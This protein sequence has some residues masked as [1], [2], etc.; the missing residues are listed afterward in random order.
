MTTTIR[1]QPDIDTKLRTL[2]MEDTGWDYMFDSGLLPC[3][4]HT[5]WNRYDWINFIG[6]H[7]FRRGSQ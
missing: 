1:E 2:N 5:L 3:S 6:D 4:A 7:W